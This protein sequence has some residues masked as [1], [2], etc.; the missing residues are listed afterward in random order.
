[1]RTFYDAIHVLRAGSSSIKLGVPKA[2]WRCVWRRR[3]RGGYFL[4]KIN[5]AAYGVAAS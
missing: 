5:A 3:T 4:F 1:M 2:R